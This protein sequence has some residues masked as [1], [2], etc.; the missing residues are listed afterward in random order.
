[1]EKT[2]I[3]YQREQLLNRLR[4][5]NP[6]WSRGAIDEA[7]DALP[8]RAYL[9]KF[10]ALVRDTDVRRGIILMGPRRV[11]KTVMI[12]HVVKRLLEDG[13][14]PR[15]IVYVSV[16]TPIFNRTSLEE[17][18][19]AARESA[20][21]AEAGTEGFYV[22][23]DEIQYL[24]DWEIHLKSMVDSYRGAKF[25]ASGSAA[26]ALRLR[27]VES[28]AGRF[29][30]FRLPPLTFRE[31]LGMRALDRLCVP[32]RMEYGG[33]T[34]E[35]LSTFDVAELNRQF[36]DYMNFGGYPEVVFSE[37]IRSD[38]GRFVRNDIIDK[39][40]L[41]D[42]PGLYG[43]ADVQELNAFFSVIAYHSGCEFSYESM[44]RTSGVKKETLKKYIEYLEAAFLIKIVKRVD[45]N[46]RRFRRMTAFKIFLTN[47][48]L[49]CALFQP[50]TGSDEML[51]SVVE[52]TVFAQLFPRESPSV[53]YANWRE[54]RA[55]GEVDVV[56]LARATQKVFW[57]SEIKW[58]DKFAENPAELKSLIRFAETAGLRDAIVTTVGKTKNVTL[59]NG[60]TLHF[61][62]A[63]VYALAL[64]ANT[65][66]GRE[67][68]PGF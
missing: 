5:D 31:F 35:Y 68:V 29:S 61:V 36:M 9:E 37:K 13:V 43:I 46:A 20:G 59:R 66:A 2:H 6:W 57:A 53:F 7:F 24:R 49:R 10:Y 55:Q 25:V 12:F 3:G 58:S 39:V 30:D 40:L 15:K 19:A 48:S 63:S 32:A 33:E 34:I 44:A 51:G 21:E 18:F 47:P 26:A 16:D 38:P 4:F 60:L 56:G 8:R 27:S 17:L 45:E 42:L 52:T 50:L 14:D 23:F 41:R 54:G 64:S 65:L 22:F 28:G 11:G 62:P 67:N 1:M